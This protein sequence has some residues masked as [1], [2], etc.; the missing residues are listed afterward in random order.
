[1]RTPKDT[2]THR[3]LETTRLGFS[4]IYRYKKNIPIGESI[5]L[6]LLHEEPCDTTEIDERE[7]AIEVQPRLQRGWH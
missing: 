1:M 6:E 2:A 7:A 4:R 3:Y 5:G